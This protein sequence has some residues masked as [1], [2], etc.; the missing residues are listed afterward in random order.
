MYNVV[1]QHT[2]DKTL[3]HSLATPIKLCQ[4]AFVELVINYNNIYNIYIRNG[5]YVH[6]LKIPTK[7]N[8]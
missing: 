5:I 1:S 3:F 6:F 7:Y 2:S 8:T 4:N